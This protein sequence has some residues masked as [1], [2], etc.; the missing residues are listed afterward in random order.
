MQRFTR[1]SIQSLASSVG[2]LRNRAS[3]RFLFDSSSVHHSTM[4]LLRLFLLAL[5]CITV[6]AL[7]ISATAVGQHPHQRQ[8]ARTSVMEKKSESTPA[9]S[10][11]QQQPQDGASRTSHVDVRSEVSSTGSSVSAQ[12]QLH[13]E[14]HTLH[15]EKE[16]SDGDATVSFHFWIMTLGLTVVVLSHDVVHRLRLTHYLSESGAVILL[17][18]VFG[19][20]VMEADILLGEPKDSLLDAIKFDHS[21]FVRFVLP[22]ILFEQGYS[23]NHHGVLENIEIVLLLAI[24]GVLLS[25]VLMGVGLY[26]SASVAYP[27]LYEA[28]GGFFLCFAVGALL[29]ATDPV[30]IVSILR[31]KFD[32]VLR[33]PTIYNVIFGESMLNDAVS[34]VLFEVALDYVNLPVTFGSV[35]HAIWHFLCVLVGSAVCGYAHGVCGVLLLRVVKFHCA[36]HLEV[37]LNVLFAAASYYLCEF[38]DLSGI[39]SLFVAA[40]MLGH[41]APKHMSLEAR[42][43]A[44]VIFR[45]LASL[46][47]SASFFLLGTAFFAYPHTWGLWFCLAT[48]AVCLISRGVVVAACARYGNQLRLRRLTYRAQIFVW[49]SGMR[50]AV[51]FGLVA[52]LVD[53]CGLIGVHDDVATLLMS[54]TL[55]VIVFTV[56]VLGGGATTVMQLLEL[57]KEETA[58]MPLTVDSETGDGSSQDSLYSAAAASGGAFGVSLAWLRKGACFIADSHTLVVSPFLE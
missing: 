11:A 12:H 26:L 13:Q 15:E 48:L 5:F 25:G 51:S 10:Q 2:E 43:H 22:V 18:I 17:G 42:Q 31:S 1:E 50:G 57:D 35:S 30:A 39:M 52:V 34:I 41:H 54:A 32:V 53:H 55:L 9:G 27:A 37:L 19:Y 8:S 20:A 3:C 24:P 28:S 47:E 33:P 46:A 4:A 40:R 44:P 16:A 29:S 14:A 56:L 45:T 49:Y 23:M 58:V 6:C 38:L 36:P 7:A 21:F